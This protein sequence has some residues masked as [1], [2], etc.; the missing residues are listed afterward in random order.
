MYVLVI[1]E[2]TWLYM[3]K[4]LIKMSSIVILVLIMLVIETTTFAADYYRPEDLTGAPSSDSEIIKNV[5]N[6]VIGVLQA[7]GIVVSVIVAIILGIKY[8][9][10][11]VDQKAEY[12]KTMLP[13][14]IGSALIFGA[15]MV[16]YII[17]HAIQF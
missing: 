1:Y 8:M 16:S 4:K 12:K 15:S 9:L 17:M 10:G 11:S 3:K 6:Q 2:G 14:A 7:I 5:G 13:Y